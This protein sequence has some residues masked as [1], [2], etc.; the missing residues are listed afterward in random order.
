MI[1]LMSDGNRTLP[2]SSTHAKLLL[3]TRHV[4]DSVKVICALWTPWVLMRSVI[5]RNE[6]TITHTGLVTRRTRVMASANTI[7]AFTDFGSYLNLST[8]WLS[9]YCR[10]SGRSFRWAH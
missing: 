10:P 5:T 3:D 4:V 7:Q 1:L 8:A 9:T 2:L 6:D